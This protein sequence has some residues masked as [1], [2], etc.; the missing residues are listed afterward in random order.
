MFNSEKINKLQS[1]LV[2]LNNSFNSFKEESKKELERLSFLLDNP[3]TFK[4]GDIPFK[5]VTITHIESCYVTVGYS[6]NG[7]AFKTWKWEIRAFDSKNKR[8]IYLKLD[9]GNNLIN[10]NK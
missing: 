9:Y 7:Y 2:Q 10:P 3:I 8:E 6:W 4:V 5:Y 1:E